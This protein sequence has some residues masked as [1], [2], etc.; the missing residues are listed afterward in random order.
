MT[1]GELIALLQTYP[2][3][4]LVFTQDPDMGYLN[5]PAPTPCNV[6]QNCADASDYRTYFG[7]GKYTIPVKLDAYII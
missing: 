3:E 4:A 7:P 1:V 5:D 6:W 2:K